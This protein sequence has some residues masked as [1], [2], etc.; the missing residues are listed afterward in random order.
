MQIG[1][2]LP[3]HER[4]AVSTENCGTGEGHSVPR[5]HHWSHL[6]EE[7]SPPRA[8]SSRV[9]C[10]AS[11]PVVR[12]WCF[13]G[14]TCLVDRVQDPERWGLRPCRQKRVREPTDEDERDPRSRTGVEGVQ[15]VSW[16]HRGPNACPQRMSRDEGRA[17]PASQL[18]LQPDP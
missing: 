9:P 10:H 2:C 3:T 18:G 4:Q 11:R 16:L 17:N 12:I 7:G 15:E 13:S 1:L 5:T 8:E 14:G 6:G